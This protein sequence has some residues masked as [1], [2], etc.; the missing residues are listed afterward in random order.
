MST[1]SDVA[2]KNDDKTQLAKDLE[3]ISMEIKGLEVKRDYLK[4]R[5]EPMMVVGERIGLV[6]KTRAEYL[7]VDGAL[8]DALEKQFG[9]EV[10]KREVNTKFLREKMSGDPELSGKIPRQERIQLRVGESYRK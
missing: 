5:L 4:S 7:M 1:A 9:A 3:T 6:E 2:K 8:L 10:V